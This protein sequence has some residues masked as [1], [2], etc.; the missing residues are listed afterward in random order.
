M[1]AKRLA[2]LL[3]LGLLAVVLLVAGTTVSAIALDALG[4]SWWTVDGGGGTSSGGGYE[5]QGSIGQPDAA[6]SIGEGY[7]LHGGF[8]NGA[9]GLLRL[10]L[11]LV[12][13]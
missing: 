13:R 11:P 9:A 4:L 12:I 6:M 8:W 1:N 3:L 7:S 5:L 2:Q 10:F